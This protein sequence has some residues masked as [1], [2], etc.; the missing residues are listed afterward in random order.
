MTRFHR[1]ALSTGLLVAGVVLIGVGLTLILGDRPA[2][3]GMTHHDF[4]AVTIAGREVVLT[5]Q[6]ELRNPGPETVTIDD[7]RASCGCTKAVPSRREIPAGESVVIESTLSLT[8]SAR[9]HAEITLA[10]A[11]E[12]LVRLT[13]EAV[14]R[15]EAR[16]SAVQ[17]TLR[18]RPDQATSMVVFLEVHDRN[19]PPP[20]PVVQ[21]PAGASAEFT[22]WEAVQR[23]D[24][25][26]AI[27][28]RWRGG[29]EFQLTGER[30]FESGTAVI[31]CDGQSLSVPL[32]PA[33]GPD[34]AEA[35]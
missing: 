20:R 6:F 23:R 12:R 16:L 14:G 9:K 30:D 8:V 33:G 32:E 2:L 5:H 4:G 34:P 29:I 18:L 26:Q 31:T 7:L 27:P 11:N 10:L 21:L 35:P 19:D 17:T 25:D 15:R 24:A 3:E 28:W 22:H 13:L 1:P